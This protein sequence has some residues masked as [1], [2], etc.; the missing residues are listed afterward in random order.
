MAINVFE[1]AR[2]IAKLVS[3]I[4]IV[5]WIVAGFQIQPSVDVTY[6][7]E[8][9]D[10]SPVRMNENCPSGSGKKYQRL[11]T[12]SGTSASI[13]FCF[14]T[15]IS[16]SGKKLIP[17]KIDRK[18]Q[19]WWG[20]EEYS[21]EVRTYTEW[22]RDEFGFSPEDEKW[23]DGRKWTSFI[24]EIGKGALVAAFGLLIFW[25]FVWSVGWIV[26]GFMGIPRGRDSK[27]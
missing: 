6:K 8:W 15:Q 27:V 3:V 19:T 11:S 26:R 22:V 13:V 2:R 25:I 12:Q 14:P 20:D 17:Y 4:W 21:S 23:V 7:I 24:Q 18:T 10:V 5:S 1:G 9:P 16:N